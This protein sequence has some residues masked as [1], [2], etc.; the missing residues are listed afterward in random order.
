ML[1]RL[2]GDPALDEDGVTILRDVITST[3]A[4]DRV[5]ALIAE[6]YE[7][8]REALRSPLVDA[9]AAEPLAALASAAT[10]RAS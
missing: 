3:H 1:R 6:R 7:L 10:R 9:A 8:A 4:L 5:E 2:L